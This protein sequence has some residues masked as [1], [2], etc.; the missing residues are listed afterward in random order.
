M[1]LSQQERRS[2]RRAY[3]FGLAHAKRPPVDRDTAVTEARRALSFLSPRDAHALV[4]EA[5]IAE[6]EDGMTRTVSMMMGAAIVAVRYMSSAS[7]LAFARTLM[8]EAH[9]IQDRVVSD[10]ATEANMDAVA[11]TSEVRWLH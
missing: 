7:Q 8:K 10:G 4:I 6:G 11:D 2:R 1:M 3:L 9:Q 5:G